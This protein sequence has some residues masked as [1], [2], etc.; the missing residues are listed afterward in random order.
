MQGHRAKKGVFI[1]TSTFTKDAQEY[2]NMVDVR[3][4]LISGTQ[5]AK[6]MLDHNVGVS[7]ICTYELKKLDLAYFTEE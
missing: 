5:L 1:T 6:L 4:V 2:T 7:T 3:M